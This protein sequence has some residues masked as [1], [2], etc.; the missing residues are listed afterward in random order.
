M[1]LQSLSLQS[2]VK[3]DVASVW[4][5][6]HQTNFFFYFFHSSCCSFVLLSFR[7][8]QRRL[9][10]FS[11]LRFLV[12]SFVSASAR[13]S[14]KTTG[15]SHRRIASPQLVCPAGQTFCISHLPSPLIFPTRFRRCCFLKKN[16]KQALVHCRLHPDVSGFDV[17]NPAPVSRRSRSLVLTAHTCFAKYSSSR[18]SRPTLRCQPCERMV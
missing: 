2:G 13:Q 5:Y 7:K 10:L 9:C 8:Q 16:R 11:V 4:L 1:P 12:A 18:C 17:L 15:C 3:K 6:L 14:K